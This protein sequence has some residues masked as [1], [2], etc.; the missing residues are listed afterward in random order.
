VRQGR[1][2]VETDLSEAQWKQCTMKANEE[3]FI[4]GV[5]CWLRKKRNEALAS[6]FKPGRFQCT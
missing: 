3:A 5:Y 6:N 2:S 1:E 4:C